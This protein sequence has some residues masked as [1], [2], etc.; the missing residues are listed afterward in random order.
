MSMSST[1]A[2]ISVP[3]LGRAGVRVTVPSSSTL[4][5]V[6]ATSMVVVSSASCLTWMV[7]M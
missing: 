6:M 5:T 7:T 4:V 3:T 1:V 2:V